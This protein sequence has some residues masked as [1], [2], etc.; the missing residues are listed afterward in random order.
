MLSIAD[1]NQRRQ[2]I[3]ASSVADLTRQAAVAAA[4]AAVAATTTPPL[5]RGWA[6]TY[7]RRRMSSPRPRAVGVDCREY[8][9][10]RDLAVTGDPASSLPSPHH[11][12][13]T[14]V[15]VDLFALPR[16]PGRNC[17]ADRPSVRPSTH[18]TIMWMIFLQPRARAF[19]RHDGNSN[20]E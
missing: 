6:H 20:N 9:L 1:R 18:P 8:S 7:W 11:L 5:R 14:I 15:V 17:A 3:P 12:I 16:L 13:P 2:P 10:R 19:Q 4:A